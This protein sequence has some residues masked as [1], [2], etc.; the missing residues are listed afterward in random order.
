MNNEQIHDDWINNNI[1]IEFRFKTSPDFFKNQ[2][3]IIQELI[4]IFSQYNLQNI[5]AISMHTNQYPGVSLT[6]TANRIGITFEKQYKLEEVIKIL[7]TSF[8]VVSRHI[9][10]QIFQRVGVRINTINKMNI[11]DARHKINTFI[12]IDNIDNELTLDS[13]NV[14]ITLNYKSYKIRMSI[15]PATVQT[16]TIVPNVQPNQI[17]QSQ[18]A[19]TGILADIDFSKLELKIDELDEFVEE[20]QNCILKCKNIVGKMS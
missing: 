17:I 14:I 11:E 7:N 18:T 13:S 6:L 10:F 20:A 19:N 1:I 16:A 12:N 5:G 8:A 2:S 15:N 9:N 4:P 3:I